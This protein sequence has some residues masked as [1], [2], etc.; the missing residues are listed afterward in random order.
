M[1]VGTFLGLWLL[2]VA[3]GLP[4]FV[5]L[6]L[7]SLASL[8]AQGDVLL[9]LPQRVTAAANSFTLL[10]APFFMLAGLAMNTSGVTNR[11]YAF[12]ESLVG[13]LRGGLAHGVCPKL[14]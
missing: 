6:G 3:L 1:T 9:A 13:W 10:A 2:L 4:L 8:W 12:A 7:A 5:T 14:S 11:I